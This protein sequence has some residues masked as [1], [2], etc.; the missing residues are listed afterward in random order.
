MPAE[1]PAQKTPHA[2]EFQGSSSMTIHERT[3][4]VHG[5]TGL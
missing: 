3:H 4:S 1:N 5:L 2:E